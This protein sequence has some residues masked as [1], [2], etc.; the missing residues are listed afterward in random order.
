VFLLTD[1]QPAVAEFADRYGDR[2]VHREAIRLE[3]IG[4]TE[5]AIDRQRDGAVLGIEV[6]LDA[7][8]AVRCDQ[9]LGDGASGVSSAIFHLKRWPADGAQL[10]REPVFL[11]PGRIEWPLT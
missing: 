2:L 7:W 10:L 6:A 3:H 1:F 9:F 8:T 4:Q 11:K 5:L